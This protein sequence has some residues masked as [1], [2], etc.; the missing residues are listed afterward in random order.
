MHKL[1]EFIG[2]EHSHYL[3]YLWFIFGCLNQWKIVFHIYK[4]STVMI[5]SC[6]NEHALTKSMYFYVLKTF[7][8]YVV[9]IDAELQ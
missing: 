7:C 6:S 1:Y 5:V 2:F 3:F 9:C 8:V 4:V